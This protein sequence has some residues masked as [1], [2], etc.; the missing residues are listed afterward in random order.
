MRPVTGRPWFGSPRGGRRILL[1][2][3]LL[4]LLSAVAALSAA[5]TLGADGAAAASGATLT[6][7]AVH[8]TDHAA[9]V[10]AAVDFSGPALTIGQVRATDPNPSDGTGGVLVSYPNVAS[11]LSP[12]IMH[13]VSVWVVE[14]PYGLSV[15]IGALPGTFKYLSYSLASPDRLVIDVWKS[16]FAPSGD[17]SGGLGGC[18]TL[19]Q[20][21]AAPGTVSA[22]GTTR[23]L[24]ESQFR[25][26]LRGA[27]GGALTSRSVTAIGRWEV[28]LHYT[29][30]QGQGGY[31][32]AAASSA[33][34]GALACLVQRTLALPASNVRANLRVV[35]RAYADVNGDGRLDLV[36]LRRTGTLKGELMVALAGGGRLSVATPSDATWLPGLVA[37]GN[38]DGRPGEELFVDTTHVSTAESIGIYADWRGSLVRAGTLPAYGNDYGVLYGITCAAQGIRHLVTDHSFYI[39]FGTHQWMRQDTVYAWQG[40]AL[41]VLAREPARRLRGAPSPALVGV[42]CGHLP[43]VSVAARD[44]RHRGAIFAPRAGSLVPAGAKAT[45]VSFVS[46]RTAFV[47]GTA[48]CGHRR[49][50]VILRTTNRGGSWV[51]LAAP[52]GAVGGYDFGG[53]WG[54]RFADERHGFAFGDGLWQ[55]SDGAA[56]WQAA[57]APAPTVLALVAAG[58]RELIAITTACRSLQPCREGSELYHRSLRAPSWQLVTRIPFGTGGVETTVGAH[59]AIVWVLAGGSHLLLSSNFGRSFHAVSQPCGHRHGYVSSVTD[60]GVHAYLLCITNSATGRSEK[61]VYIAGARGGAWKLVGYPPRSGLG[62]TLAAGSDSSLVLVCSS[63]ASWLY[64]SADAGWHWSTALAEKDGGAGWGDI[65]FTSALDGYVIHAPARTNS[66]SVR[67][68]QLLLTGDGGHTW[69]VTSLTSTASGAR[70]PAGSRAQAPPASLGVAA[71]ASLRVVRRAAVTRLREHSVLVGAWQRLPAAPSPAATAQTVSVWTGKEMVIFGRAYPKPPLGIDVAAAY[72]PAS[73]TWRRLAPLKGPAGNF[74]G[75]YHA[76]WTGKEMLVL[77]AASD[78]QAYDPVRNRWRHPAAPPTGVDG[79]GLVVWTGKE[80]I[81]W[82]GGCCGDALATGWAFNPVTNRWRKLPSSPLAPSQSPIGVWTGHDLIALVSGLDPDGKPYPSRFAR[83]AAYN[84]V[85]NVW[86]RL[87]LLPASRFNADAVWDGHEMLLVGGIGASQG[88]RP[89][90]PAKVG[91]AYNPKT[92]RWRALAPMPTGRTNFPVVWSGKR[93]LIWGGSTPPSGIA[94]DP[95]ANRWSGL[96]PAPLTGRT[97]L[98]AVWTG[99]AMILWGGT[100]LNQQYKVFTEGAAFT[101]AVR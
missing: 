33:K 77:G 53:L 4:L 1:L 63:A 91:F 56:S 21:N 67:G 57:P 32:E 26:V 55:T 93:L 81:D 61:L 65:G 89:G 100:I 66:T 60:D 35:Y 10:E 84:P 59:G 14:V 64:R 88:G 72:V 15:G 17:I 30:P 8:I 7:T 16:A 36:T 50:S 27:S 40:P 2:L 12:V 101:P 79:A 69:H 97:S 73:D 78:F 20:V 23:G 28:T 5:L 70:A 51:A 11:H 38:V 49:C 71:T 22:S 92:N 6:A 58:D 96:P 3:L 87:A 9:Y 80:M 90:S 86:R 25:V 83:I 45:S 31:F 62:G 41:K 99:R 75:E 39:R 37:T 48:P 19:S 98:T 95:A 68:G 43:V 54:V 52:P 94:Y 46:S 44:I 13:G 34:D 82:G 47:L 76:V 18:L 42:Q 24:F 29:A 85:S 74:Q